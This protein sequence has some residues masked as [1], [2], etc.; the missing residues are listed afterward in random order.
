MQLPGLCTKPVGGAGQVL[1]LAEL[2]LR[3]VDLVGAE[4]ALQDGGERHTFV[5]DGAPR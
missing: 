1:G 4:G 3:R 5:M 2:P